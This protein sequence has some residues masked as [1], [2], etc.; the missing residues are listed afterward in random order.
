MKLLSL[1]IEVFYEGGMPVIVIDDYRFFNYFL[2]NS[3]HCSYGMSRFY[4]H[5]AV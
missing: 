3:S 5:V 1:S 2:F 4:L